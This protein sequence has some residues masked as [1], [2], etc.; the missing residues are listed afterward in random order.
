MVRVTK[1]P[2][3]PKEGR[4]GHP[5][6]MCGI[7]TAAGAKARVV[8]K[9]DVATPPARSH[10]IC[11]V[12]GC[13]VLSHSAG[14]AGRTSVLASDYVCLSS[15]KAFVSFQLFERPQAK[16]RP[17]SFSGGNVLQTPAK[18]SCRSSKP[19][20]VAASGGTLGGSERRSGRAPGRIGFPRNSRIRWFKFEP[21]GGRECRDPAENS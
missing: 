8:R 1:R 19:N 18:W 6:M 21:C 13:T 14:A 3:R 7:I 2:T 17:F 9:V 12:K 16:P 20:D 11:P 5:A 4:L 10:I 15:A